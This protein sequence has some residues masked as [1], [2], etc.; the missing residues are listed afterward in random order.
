MTKIEELEKAK[1]NVAWLLDHANGSVDMK[2]LV[3]WAGRVE[4][5]RKEVMASL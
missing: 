1:H 4:A 5:L 2:G 3:Y